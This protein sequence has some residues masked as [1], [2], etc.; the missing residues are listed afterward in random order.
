MI[1][2]A[3]NGYGINENENIE[4]THFLSYVIGYFVLQV[5]CIITTFINVQQPQAV[6]PTL[7]S[8]NVMGQVVTKSKRTTAL[9]SIT[10]EKPQQPILPVRILE[11]EATIENRPTII[12]EK[13]PAVLKYRTPHFRA[14]ATLKFP[15]LDEGEHWKIGWIQSC[16]RMDF[17]NSYGDSGYSSWEFPQLMSG[18]SPMI[19]DSDGRNYPFYGSKSE[20]IELQGPFSDYR[21]IKVLMNDN[22]YPHITWDIPTSN[23]R[24]SRLTNVKRHQRFYTWLVAMNANNGS[25]LVLKTINWQMDL[26]IN[27]DPTKPQ[28]SRAI[29]ISNPIPIQPEILKQ[30][31]RI[32]TCVLYPPNANSA[33]ILVWHPGCRLGE[34]SQRPE[35][36]VPPRCEY[37]LHQNPF[38]DHYIR[39]KTHTSVQNKLNG[40]SSSSSSENKINITQSSITESYC[41]LIYPQPS[42]SKPPSIPGNR[43][44]NGV[45][46]ILEDHARL[47]Q[48]V[49]VR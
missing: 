19:S 39:H 45:K 15:P 21:T 12:D 17:Y 22:F 2:I 33:Q 38:Y 10:N 49:I 16:T 30:N 14:T 25:I 42:H 32:P 37:V 5:V 13:S 44:Y 24:L 3:A 18:Q 34:I 26:E 11:L 4:L 6:P 29:L 9:Q 41:R 43:C 28:G 31:I 40:G 1:T 47:A 20:V 27:V 36:V 23:E 7:P 48:G 35:I 46:H 8:M